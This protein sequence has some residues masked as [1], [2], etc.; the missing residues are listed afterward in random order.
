MPWSESVPAEIRLKSKAAEKAARM[1]DGP[2]IDID[3]S[4]F[5]DDEE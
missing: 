5:R 4:A 2:I 1:A 3:L